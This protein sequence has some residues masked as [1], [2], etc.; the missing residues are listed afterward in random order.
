MHNELCSHSTADIILAA[1]TCLISHACICCTSA[2]N[3]S[4]RME[5]N[6]LLSFSTETLETQAC[7]TK[8]MPAVR[9][10]QDMLGIA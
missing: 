4:K 1:A 10:E 8:H 9:I 3:E 5:A 6:L 2:A 7:V